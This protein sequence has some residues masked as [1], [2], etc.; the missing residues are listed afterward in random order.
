[1]G[2][3]KLGRQLGLGKV[4]VGGVGLGNFGRQLA[5]AEL[6]YKTST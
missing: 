6:L 3:R 4:H 1:M 5:V 2:V